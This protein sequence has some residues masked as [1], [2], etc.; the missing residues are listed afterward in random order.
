ML[1]IDRL[2]YRIA[3]R[4]LLEGATARLP[5]GARIGLVGRNGSGK[6]TLLD[7]IAG[8]LAPDDG[9]IRIRNHVR[10]GTVAQETPTGRQSP[11]ELVL[12]ADTERATL[13][14]EAVDA[15]DPHRVA[16]IHERLADIEAHRAE[17]RAASILAGLGFDEA[18]HWTNRPTIW[19]WK[20]RCGWRA[21]WPAI[22]IPCC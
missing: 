7:L 21:S 11:L 18:A 9:D 16:E 12:A 17:A 2:T 22:P 3:G 20:P 1:T 14:A 8:N 6:S 13:L 15:S 4:T 5:A 10:I 19:T